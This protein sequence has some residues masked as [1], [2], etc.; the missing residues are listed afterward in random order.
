[1]RN[2]RL[3]Q[4]TILIFGLMLIIA[5]SGIFSIIVSAIYVP[6]PSTTHTFV[7]KGYVKDTSGR[8]LSNAKVKLTYGSPETG[9]YKV[10][11]TDSNGY[12][13]ISVETTLYVYCKLSASRTGYYSQTKSVYSSGTKTV[14]FYLEYNPPI[15]YCKVGSVDPVTYGQTG[16]TIN[17]KMTL[18]Q[19]Y[20]I[21]N[22]E[23]RFNFGSG[24][25][26]LT[27]HGSYGWELES[28]SYRIRH[29][30]GS[31]S[32]LLVDLDD[33]SNGQLYYNDNGYDFGYDLVEMDYQFKVYYGYLGTGDRIK[34]KV[35]TQ[36]RTNQNN[37]IGLQSSN[38]WGNADCDI[39]FDD[40]EQWLQNYYAGVWDGIATSDYGEFM[41]EWA[42]I[43]VEIA[44]T[45]FGFIDPYENSP[46]PYFLFHKA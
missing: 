25:V 20:A 17:I 21:A 11:Y 3:K 7:V 29:Q 37:I 6:P 15:Y 33:V 38:I 26:L 14:S 10:D 28:S 40:E 36:C 35:Q 31:T 34:M 39:L 44:S 13:Y 23:V 45:I 46:S 24:L 2:N 43:Y 1:M 32:P 4:K 22:I 41:S 8:P 27:D 5:G 16:N 42:Q 9:I 18:Y 30:D 19:S 12:Y